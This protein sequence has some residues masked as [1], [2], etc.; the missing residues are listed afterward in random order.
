MNAHRHE[1]PLLDTAEDWVDDE[2]IFP[3]NFGDPC[4][5]CGRP[6]LSTIHSLCASCEADSEGRE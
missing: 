6:T 1:D 2:P 3:D 4:A 5:E